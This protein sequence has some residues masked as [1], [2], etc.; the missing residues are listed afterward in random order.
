MHV[1]KHTREINTNAESIFPSKTPILPQDKDNCEK[2]YKI[3]E[4]RF[5]VF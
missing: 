2:P 1:E 3:R 5:F 4:M